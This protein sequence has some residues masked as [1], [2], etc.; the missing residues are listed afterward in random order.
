MTV[1]H[2]DRADETGRTGRHRAADTRPPSVRADETGRAGRHRAADT[3]P[4]SVRADETGRAG[5]RPP[6]PPPEA[7]VPAISTALADPDR[8]VREAGEAALD[9]LDWRPLRAMGDPTDLPDAVGRMMTVG[10]DDANAAYYRVENLIFHNRHSGLDLTQAAEPVAALVLTAIRS[11]SWTPGGLVHGLDMLVEIVMGEPDAT[12]RARGNTRLV[13]RCRAVVRAALPELYALVDRDEERILQ[14][15][16]D[17]AAELEPDV[18]RR[19]WVY[20]TVRGRIGR[21]VVLNSLRGL[22]QTLDPPPRET[23]SDGAPPAA[24]RG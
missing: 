12:E 15:V 10:D 8:D 9:R 17:L 16:I 7:L 6:A 4:P 13:E 23:A 22:E 2:L 1:R 24:G 11:G 19:R 21:R 5:R 18:E 14:G 20:E 3:R